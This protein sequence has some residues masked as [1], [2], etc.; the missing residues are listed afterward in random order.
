MQE[1]GGLITSY[2]LLKRDL[3]AYQNLDF[4]VADH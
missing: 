3:K 2:D 4:A 1:K